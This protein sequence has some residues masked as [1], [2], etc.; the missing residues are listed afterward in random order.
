[1]SMNLTYVCGTNKKT[2]GK[3]ERERGKA[4]DQSS[5]ALIKAN[6]YGVLIEVFSTFE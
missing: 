5:I 3:R 2:Q 6:E 4:S 1:M